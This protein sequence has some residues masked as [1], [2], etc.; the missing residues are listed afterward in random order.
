M[1]DGLIEGSVSGVGE[2]GDFAEKESVNSR[3]ILNY[4]EN[5]YED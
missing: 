4:W 2:A 3:N 5:A 1:V